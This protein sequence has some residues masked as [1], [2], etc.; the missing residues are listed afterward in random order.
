M[1]T[2]AEIVLHE[3]PQAIRRTADDGAEA[4]SPHREAVAGNG[5]K[6]NL[7][8]FAAILL[9]AAPARAEV[10]ITL[11]D[12]TEIVCESIATTRNFSYCVSENG[13]KKR[14]VNHAEVWKI[15]IDG[16]EFPTVR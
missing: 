1:A 16:K 4:G 7:I 2:S 3:Y 13:E 15:I 8:A 12:G 10:V 6:R 14:P 11:R 5:V 9:V